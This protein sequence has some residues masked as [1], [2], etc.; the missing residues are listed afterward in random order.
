MG[1]ISLSPLNSS[2][3]T[4]GCHDTRTRHIM[5]CSAAELSILR[6]HSIYA[7][8]RKQGVWHHHLCLPLRVLPVLSA[9]SM[10]PP[11]G[12]QLFQIRIK[13]SQINQQLNILHV[14]S[15][16]WDHWTYKWKKIL[17]WVKHLKNVSYNMYIRSDTAALG[18]HHH[19]YLLV[20]RDL[21]YQDFLPLLSDVLS[22]CEMFFLF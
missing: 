11:S 5:A 2:I 16:C 12:P 15:K 10:P 13:L 9:E 22:Q 6:F 8:K 3:D 4:T 7:E 1:Y 17:G 14:S 20:V 18:Q 21:T 19:L